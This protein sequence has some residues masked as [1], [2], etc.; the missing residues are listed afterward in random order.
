VFLR[1][2]QQRFNSADTSRVARRRRRKYQ[3]KLQT[4]EPRSLLSVTPVGVTIA[5]TEATAFTGTVASFTATDAGPFSAS[6]NWGDGTTT[7]GTVAINVSG[8][9][10]V[11]GTHTYG[12]DGTEAVSVA[13]VDSADSTTATAISTANVREGSFALSGVAP[14]SAT[15]GQ[16][17][18]GITVATFSDS[19]SPDAASAFTASINWGDGTT[20]TG[21]VTGSGGT[22]TVSGTHAFA[23]ELSG[24][25]SVTVN[26]PAANF[27]IGPNPDSLTVA[28]ADTLAPTGF[29]VTTGDV[30]EGISFGG[31][32]AVFKDSGY[33]GNVA[34]DFTGTFDWGDGTTYTTGAG[35]L[36]ITTDG[37]GD[38]TL[39]VAGHS[40]ADEGV[41][42]VVATLADNAPGTASLAQ[43]GT[44]TVTET[45][46]FTPAATPATFT[47]TEGTS[48]SG[49]VA[50][51]ADTAFPTNSAADFTATVNWGDGTVTAGTV[52]G[53]SGANLTVSGT[54][55]YAED[56]TLHPVVTI[57]DNAPGTAS[58]TATATANVA[59]ASLTV[60]PIAVFA[61]TEGTSNSGVIAT[62]SDP[63]STD[64]AAGYSATINWG[65]GTTTSGTVTGSAGSYT[66]SGAHTYADEGSFTVTVTASEN[67]AVPTATASATVVG[68]VA[69][70]DTLV[71]GSVTVGPTEGATFAGAVA[72]FSNAGYSANVA[73]DFTST[74][75]W[76]DG[77]T[78]AGTV[79]GGSGAD[80]TVSGS[81]T[82]SDEGTFT[83]TTTLAD[84]APGTA[85]ATATSTANVAE[86]DSGSLTA[87]TIT[88]T[89]GAAFSG[90]VGSFTDPGNPLQ[91]AG[92]FTSSI[93]W[94]DGTTT[95]GTVSGP[96]GGPFT[97]SGSHTYADEGTFTVLATFSDD[98]PSTLTNISITSTATVSETDTLVPG[99]AVT[100]SATEGAT[101]TG[102][103]A[104]FADTT[105]AANV[106][107]DFTAVINWGDGTTT[108]GTVSG[109]AGS[110]TVSGSHSYAE[111]GTETATVI[112]SDNA[113]G[114]ATGTAT[115][116]INV[117]DATLTAT[118]TT[119][120]GTEGLLLT[121]VVAN[122]TDADPAGT[123]ADYTAT[124][125]WGDGTTSAGTV[126]A[127]GGSFNVTGTHTYLEEGTDAVQVVIK[128]VGG[129]TATAASTA[130]IADAAL[131]A[132]GT[133]VTSPE[134][135][136]FSGVVG[137][138]T[139]ADPNGTVTDY[140]ATVA[141]GDGA[142]TA[143]TVTAAGSGF[144][145]SGSHTYTEDGSYTIKVSIAD[146]GGSKASATSTATISE[147]TIS[148][149]AVA[150][151]GFERSSATNVAVATFTHGNGAEP[152]SGFSAIINW[153]DGTTSSA[154]VSESGTTYTISGSHTYLDEGTFPVIAAV[155][156]DTASATVATSAKVG[157]EL[158]PNGTTGTAN[159]RFISE[160]YRDLFHRAV[161]SSGLAL[162]SG[163]LDQGQSRLQVVSAIIATAMPG[164]LGG[165][166]VTGMYQKYLGRAPDAQGLAF[167][168]GIVSQKETIEDTEAN[169]VSTPEFFALSG[170]T[171]AGYIT[172]LFNL[173]LGRAP[174]SQGMS[175]LLA[176]MSNGATREQIAEIVF[177][178]HEFHEIEVAG[179]YQ[180][181]VDPNDRNSAIV[182]FIDDLDFLDRPGDSGGQAFVT[183]LDHGVLDQ[184]IWAEFLA[185]NEF[186]A[187]TA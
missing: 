84:D 152:A 101:F 159:E 127:S 81:H 114:T 173:A 93:D 104:T 153:G 80:L 139:D 11:T 4:L 62:I 115:A 144:Q 174:D 96:T 163:L 166:L 158:L 133:T 70:A 137:T 131:T 129:S 9:F 85:S 165:D 10:N 117:A 1:N 145:V 186:F 37:V 2:W 19:G 121:A 90:P 25:I 52:S 75:N 77:T 6:I 110:F 68:T 103:V 20:T 67:S 83:V 182:P 136:A 66:V 172:R 58:A 21:T 72:T 64:P 151:A 49:Q 160:V 130:N 146:V 56:G 180:S 132:T 42:T 89:E 134:F 128:D 57:S 76:G 39:A 87:S 107:G 97:I 176:D 29:G 33:T 41:F 43:T 175:S 95:T 36:S 157:E 22:F 12:E 65:D 168:V 140:T 113:P 135:T 99:T 126:A 156:D 26:E 147:P 125:T 82:Y 86:G 183:E 100:A 106:A 45:D 164:E 35:N 24:Q 161:D 177:N 170:S 48:S 124:I 94:G 17:L 149:S 69:E 91:V 55:T 74:I 78:T 120:A 102:T 109:S 116:T 51:F 59:E 44:L 98:P 187:K 181:K 16:T 73:G 23:D 40:Y 50:I 79:S 15:E 122:F 27:T 108:A 142:T 38:F 3:P 119:I 111:E 148:G 171:N 155:A 118:G 141:W 13:I 47:G 185:S 46:S 14:I 123:V 53:G 60:I 178:S 167:W 5:P 63:G 18:S 31:P 150:L 169:L 8:G 88:P 61:I 154:N 162:W 112:L 30:A 105:Y 92:D 138:F 34:A 54:H 143:G 71:A 179:Y 32:A 184:V 7:A 28:E